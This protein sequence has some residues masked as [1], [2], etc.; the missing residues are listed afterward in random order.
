MSDI[1]QNDIHLQNNAP[2]SDSTTPLLWMLV[3]AGAMLLA[4][5][6]LMF[7]AAWVA[8]LALVAIG[9]L[10][11]LSVWV[12]ASRLQAATTQ[13]EQAS[14]QAGGD[15]PGQSLV[16]LLQ[17]I[18][19]A[20]QHHVA[21]VKSQTEDAVIKLTTSF[22]KVLEQFDLAGIGSG[23]KNDSNENITLLALCERELQPVVGSLTVVIEGKDSMLAN[24]RHLSIETK[25]L[26]EMADEVGSIAAQ[27]NLLAI[28]AAIEAARAGES[29]RGFAV[30][31]AEVRLLSQRSASTGLRIASRVKEVTTVMT[32]TMNVAEETNKQDRLAVSLSGSIVEDVL[33]HVRAMGESSDM[34]KKHSSIV[35]HEV[36]NLLMAM[37]FQD[38]VSQ[39]LSGVNDD[40]VRLAHAMESS[41]DNALPSVQEWMESLS[42]TYT[43]EDQKHHR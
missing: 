39:M 25:A 42:K 26:Q 17:D 35:R 16:Y 33:N 2:P 11:G 29:G 23:N 13:A 6:P 34:M 9:V 4:A 12:L 5:L 15:Q 28:N 41:S 27:T 7:D 3:P 43:M 40:M 8:W 36:E 37:Q 21:T 10:T 18:L 1:P 31:A 24:I 19:P 32:E 22:S 30:V 38:R 14:T 20:W